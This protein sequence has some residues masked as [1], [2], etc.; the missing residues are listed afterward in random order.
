[1]YIQY[2]KTKYK[3]KEYTSV[4]FAE[5]YHQNGKM[6]RRI[7]ANLSHCPKDLVENIQKLLKDRKLN[8]AMELPIK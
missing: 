3:D 4:I 6:K 7:I 5:S 2:I 1:M 8:H